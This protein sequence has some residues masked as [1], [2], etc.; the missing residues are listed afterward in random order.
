MHLRKFLIFRSLVRNQRVASVAMVGL[1]I[2]LLPSMLIYAQTPS[3]SPTQSHVIRSVVV[4][5][6]TNLSLEFEVTANDDVA[7]QH[8]NLL[9]FS[10]LRSTTNISMVS[11]IDPLQRE[12]WRKTPAELG[13]ISRNVSSHPELGDTILLPELRDATPGRWRLRLERNPRPAE[14]GQV[15]FS[16]RLLPRFQL[17]MT[18][19]STSV[20]AGQPVLILLR[21]TDYGVPVVDM[22]KFDLTVFDV[23]GVRVATQTVQ[24]NTRTPTGIPISTESGTYMTRFSLTKTGNY[25]LV[26]Q[27]TFPGRSGPQIAQA[28]LNLKVGAGGGTVALSDVRFETQPTASGATASTCISAVI[29]DFAVDVATAG[30]YACNVALTTQGST[31]GRFVSASAALPIGLGRISV[32]A[33]AAI[34]LTLGSPLTQLSQVGLIRYSDGGGGLIA[35]A[36]DIPLTVAQ[37][38]ELAQLCKK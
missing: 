33:N 16:Y 14:I 23:R 37:R 1:C 15:L 17:S 5:D 8:E 2:A 28:I 7:Q 22:G 9:I 10:P 3:T 29:F 31:T 19:L 24:E 38:T 34:L 30:N 26:A 6:Q 35:E 4:A 13:I 36:K 11:L 27:Q 21:P 32:K 12:I 20:A 25:R 18:T